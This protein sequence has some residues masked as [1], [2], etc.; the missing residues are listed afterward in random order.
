MACSYGNPKRGSPRLLDYPNSPKATRSLEIPHFWLGRLMGFGAATLPS[1]TMR[2][3]LRRERAS[4]KSGRI[5][6]Q[7]LWSARVIRGNIELSLTAPALPSSW[8]VQ[9]G[10]GS[11]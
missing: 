7:K 11:S 6:Q 1:E 3:C 2:R 4:N 8:L 10:F 5:E 9:T